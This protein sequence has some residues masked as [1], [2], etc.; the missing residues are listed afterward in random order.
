MLRRFGRLVVVRSLESPA[1]GD[2]EVVCQGLGIGHGCVWV[3]FV[4]CGADFGGV[5]FTLCEHGVVDGGQPALGCLLGD[6]CDD[7]GVW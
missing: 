2:E 6:L 4:S 7:D 1:C 5:S 3:V